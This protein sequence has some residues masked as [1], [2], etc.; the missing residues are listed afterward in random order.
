VY[1][2]ESFANT[3]VV[4][5]NFGR[6]MALEDLP[7]VINAGLW[8]RKGTTTSLIPYLGIMYKNMQA[9][10]TYDININTNLVQNTGW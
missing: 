9:G 7:T 6:I 5:A 3:M 8:Y 4:G 1:I 2:S 10:I